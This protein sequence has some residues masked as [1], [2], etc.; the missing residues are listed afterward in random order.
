MEIP[1]IPKKKVTTPVIKNPVIFPKVDCS[2]NLSISNATIIKNLPALKI[3]GLNQL[4]TEKEE[5]KQ[6]LIVQN[7]SKKLCGTTPRQIIQMNPNYEV[8]HTASKSTGT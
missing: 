8:E 3:M 5:T 4:L 2:T 7:Q 6:I 1:V